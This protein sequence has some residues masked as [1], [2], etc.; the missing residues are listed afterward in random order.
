MREVEVK[1]EVNESTISSRQYHV[2][3]SVVLGAR[4]LLAEALDQGM[5]QISLRGALG[6]FTASNFKVPLVKWEPQ[7]EDIFGSLIPPE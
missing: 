4:R 6:V 5:I 3:E 2:R 1:C 7:E